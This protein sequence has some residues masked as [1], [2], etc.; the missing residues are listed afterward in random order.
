MSIETFGK[1]AAHIISMLNEF[2]QEKRTLPYIFFDNLFASFTLL[3]Y[4]KDKL[5]DACGTIRN[6]SQY[7]YKIKNV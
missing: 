4:L 3:T 7:S 2:P 1:A 5:Y 6:S